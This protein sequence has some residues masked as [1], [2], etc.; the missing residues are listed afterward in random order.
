MYLLQAM[1]PSIVPLLGPYL[2]DLSRLAVP[3]GQLH[4][5]GESSRQQQGIG[6]QEAAEDAS[7]GGD[8]AADRSLLAGDQEGGEEAVGAEEGGGGGGGGRRSLAR[9]ER[10]AKE[11]RARRSSARKKGLAS[12]QPRLQ[13][14][15]GRM[16][17][18]AGLIAVPAGTGGRGPGAAGDNNEEGLDA[19]NRPWGGERRIGLVVPFVGFEDLASRPKVGRATPEARSSE[20]MLHPLGLSYAVTRVDTVKSLAHRVTGALPCMRQV[21]LDSLLP[22]AALLATTSP[23]R[24]VRVAACEFLHSV[25]LWLVSREGRGRS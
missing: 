11:A 24:P 25:A 4:V 14:W 19:V 13:L 9:E 21:W 15:L 5:S 17:S 18:A 12:L 6:S 3:Q 22:R 2:Q 16:G 10:E 1:L 20:R 7:N 8:T 23:D